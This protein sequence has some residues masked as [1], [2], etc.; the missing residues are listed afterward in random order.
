MIVSDR[1][2]L[3]GISILVTRA[4]GQAEQL[5]RLIEER[6]GTAVVVPTIE[7]VPPAGWEACDRAIERLSAYDGVLFTSVDHLAGSEGSTL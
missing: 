7:I 5:V 3:H 4:A 2:A 6:G 1:S